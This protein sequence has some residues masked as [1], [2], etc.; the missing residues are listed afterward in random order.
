M[1]L[2]RQL[3]DFVSGL[4]LARAGKWALAGPQF[5]RCVEVMNHANSPDEASLS[6]L[7]AATC[8][9]YSGNSA[10]AI[11]SFSQICSSHKEET[12]LSQAALRY[13]LATSSIALQTEKLLQECKTS[14]DAY[15][16]LT[17]GIEPQS[18]TYANSV[19]DHVR[20]AGEAELSFPSSSTEKIAHAYALL[21]V[22][23]SMVSK[24]PKA[25]V[26]S[27][28]VSRETNQVGKALKA[29][30][31]IGAVGG[32]LGIIS[33][34]YI[35]RSLLLRGRLFQFNANALMAEGMYR[36]AAD[37]TATAVTPR[38]KLLNDAAFNHLGELLWKWE[39]REREG[40]QLM[41]DHPI[42]EA[43]LKN[44]NVFVL[45]PTMDELEV[46][47]PPSALT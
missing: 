38:L 3:P 35:A 31:L 36:A 43:Y 4:S 37:V 23:D 42:S 14:K 19:W 13:S 11:R 16:Q 1:S 20:T 5:S 18:G 21:S 17:A 30:E 40:E 2:V 39:R 28:D 8:E 46:I 29:G 22:A 24:L 45:E 27:I 33:K 10:A 12:A 44:M 26:D 34:W 6:A 9:Y 25:N 47:Q 15:L 41:K 32:E 7:Y